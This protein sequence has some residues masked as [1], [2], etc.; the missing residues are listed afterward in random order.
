MSIKKIST[1]ALLAATM[2]LYMQTASAVIISCQRS[3]STGKMEATTAWKKALADEADVACEKNGAFVTKL[4]LRPPV[5]LIS[6]QSA[7]Q[8]VAQPAQMDRVSVTINP[9]GTPQP[10]PVIAAP[11]PTPAPAPL[12]QFELVK[13]KRV[14]DQLRAFGK[15]TGWDHFLWQA[16]EYVLDQNILIPGDFEAAITYF[17]KGANEAGSHLRAVFYRGNKTVRI[18]EF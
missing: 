8:T 14:D 15:R 2:L 11:A 17:L 9:A 18:T 10:I 13:G 6:T 1:L 7:E 16:P 3:A 5:L 4:E 12:P